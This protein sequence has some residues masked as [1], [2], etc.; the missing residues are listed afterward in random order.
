M[1]ELVKRPTPV[2]GGADSLANALIRNTDERP[3]T[4]SPSTDKTIL[5]ILERTGQVGDNSL[6][7]SLL[8]NAFISDIAQK[9]KEIKAPETEGLSFDNM[10][11]LTDAQKTLFTT[12]SEQISEQGNMTRNSL[13]EQLSGQVRAIEQASQDRSTISSIQTGEVG[14]GVERSTRNLSFVADAQANAQEQVVDATKSYVDQIAKL[15]LQERQSQTDILSQSIQAEEQKRA[16]LN[17]LANMLTESLGTVHR[18]GDDGEVFDTG[19]ATIQGRSA[20]LDLQAG[21]FQLRTAQAEA[22]EYYQLDS[23]GMIKFGADGQ[24]LVT[25]FG[26]L[27]RQADKLLTM[28]ETEEAR[29]TINNM[30]Q[31][32]E[33]MNMF[34]SPD[35]M[36]AAQEKW[37]SAVGNYYG[38]TMGENGMEGF[39]D[40]TALSQIGLDLN[41]SFQGSDGSPISGE[42]MQEI[43]QMMALDISSAMFSGETP[44]FMNK[45]YAESDDRSKM[46][47]ALRNITSTDNG[48]EQGYNFFEMDTSKLNS[49]DSS[50]L[51]N[52]LSELDT[53][54][55]SIFEDFLSITRSFEGKGLLNDERLGAS[56]F[57]ERLN[58]GGYNTARNNEVIPGVKT[59]QLVGAVLMGTTAGS[60]KN[61]EGMNLIRL[62]DDGFVDF[63]PMRS[64]WV[65]NAGDA[66]MALSR[67]SFANNPEGLKKV[68]SAYSGNLK[69]DQ[70]PENSKVYFKQSSSGNLSLDENTR[71]LVDGL[72]NVQ[73]FMEK[74]ISDPKRLQ[75]TYKAFLTSTMGV[76][77]VDGNKANDILAMVNTIRTG[78]ASNSKKLSNDQMMDIYKGMINR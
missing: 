62:S 58:G 54:S 47:F 31:Q 12:T 55:P 10:P 45:V 43:R 21:Q 4:T 73:K 46:L 23:D 29:M 44:A 1:S 52:K 11:L 2:E 40:N 32:Q 15:D 53:A 7:R 66:I 76:Y 26:D 17:N 61:L 38:L 69:A 25:D 63:E 60:L 9:T 59:P 24:A 48:F 72:V 5:S 22:S 35:S 39:Y 13:A 65:T 20:E 50:D 3:S 77:G 57:L 28:A 42:N 37:G 49:K 41:T 16:E 56:N 33:L 64:A 74:S 78:K 34:S 36:V 19:I 18:L 30:V 68:L 8:G 71:K 6:N 27:R 67:G 75:D 70:V 51:K 14:M